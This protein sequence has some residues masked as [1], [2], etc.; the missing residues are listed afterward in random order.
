MP[1]K[2][3]TNFEGYFRMVLIFIEV[4]LSLIEKMT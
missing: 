3:A 4:Y 2:I 1:L